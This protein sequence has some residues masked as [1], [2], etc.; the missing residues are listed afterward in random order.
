VPPPPPPPKTH[1]HTQVQ[2]PLDQAEKLSE[3]LGNTLLLKREDL[4]PVRCVACWCRVC[5]CV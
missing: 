4:Q 5:V 1:T 2:T 3:A